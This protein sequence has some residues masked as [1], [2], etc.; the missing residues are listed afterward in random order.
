MPQ[1]AVFARPDN[2]TT[3]P[4][5]LPGAGQGWIDAAW[6]TAG[7][8]TTDPEAPTALESCV[9]LFRELSKKAVADCNA[10][11]KKGRQHQAELDKIRAE[12]E[13]ELLR[14][15]AEVR[16]PIRNPPGIVGEGYLYVIA[17]TTGTVKVGQTEDPCR[18]LYT[19]QA[20][21]AAFGVG[22][23]AYW[24]SPSH[25]NFKT[26]ET[27]LI[28]QCRK[29]SRRS[30]REFFH[31]IGYDAAVDIAVYLDFHSQITNQVCV[32]MDRR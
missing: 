25:T 13:A 29:V 2:A 22:A 26:N 7:V 12:G 27:L 24:I 6:T 16:M 17:F 4:G 10:F 20:E 9:A 28:E 11:Y 23:N 15:C 18:R 21:A 30:R 8:S 31:G 19:H 3:D 32:E 1:P 14:A 5:T